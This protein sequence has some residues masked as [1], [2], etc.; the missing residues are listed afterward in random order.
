MLLD[1]LV[2]VSLVDGG[3]VCVTFTDCLC[4]IHSLT[5]CGVLWLC[6]AFTDCIWRSMTF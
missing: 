2:D 4:G 6:V 5:I 3:T 1:G